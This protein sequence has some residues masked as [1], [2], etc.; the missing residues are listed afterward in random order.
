MNMMSRLLQTLMLCT[1]LGALAAGPDSVAKSDRSLWP[2]KLDSSK[3]FDRASRAEIL[4]FADA[5]NQLARQ[6]DL[7]AELHLKS[8]DAASVAK[9]SERLSATLLSNYREA[10][11]AC[12]GKE[13]LCDKLASA[14]DLA[15][16]GAALDTQLPA[17]YQPWLANARAFHRL[18]AMELLRLAALFPKVSS[19]IDVFSPAEKT[20][21]EL[22]DRHFLFTF[23]DG[24]TAKGGSTDALLDTLKQNQIHAMFYMLGDHLKPR[25]DADAAL[26]QR[27]DGQCVAL[28]G[29]EHQSHQK[30]ADWQNSVLNTQKLAQQVFG[31]AYRPYFRPPY[32][33]RRPDSAAFFAQNQLQVALWN[34]DSQDWNAKISDVEAAQRVMSLMLLWRR[35][36]ILFHDIHPKANRAVPWLVKSLAGSGVSWDRCQ[37]Y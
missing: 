26:K 27:Y 14:A 3:G 5:L 15:R 34:I 1:A 4:V 16:S 24:P 30:W 32:G 31:E 25:S 18:Y 36:V 2:D 28:H 21:F 6:D 9:I 33:Q 8:V 19:E 10:S 23:D 12:D 17:P 11:T 7:K 20:G 22:A 13:I 29:W 37:Q 35:G